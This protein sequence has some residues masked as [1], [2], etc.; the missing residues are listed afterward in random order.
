MRAPDTCDR[1][2]GQRGTLRRLLA[3]TLAAVAAMGVSTSLAEPND[4]RKIV[5]LRIDDVQTLEHLLSSDLNPLACRTALGESDWV[6]SAREFEAL[7]ARG[8][9]TRTL[10]ENVEALVANQRASHDRAGQNSDWYATYRTLAEIETRLSDLASAHPER[11]SLLNLGTSAEGRTIW[12]MKVRGTDAPGKPAVL[13]NGTQHAREWIAAMV[14]VFIA[15]TLAVD[16]ASDPVVGDLLDAVD[17]YV[18][19]VVNPDGYEY[20][21]TTDRFWRKN[22]SNNAGSSCRGVDLN[23]NWDKDWN[24]SESTSNSPCSSVFVGS[25]AF[26]EPE[27]SALRDF[28]LAHPEL[29]GHIDFHNY[30]QVILQ[31]WGY[32]DELPDDF[33]E[34]DALGAEMSRAIL[35]VHGRIYPH[36]SGSGLLYL[37]SGIAPDW[38]HDRSIFGYT[39]ELRPSG[40]G[41]GGFELPPGEIRPTAEENYAGALKMIQWARPATCGNDTL[42]AGEEC[43]GNIDDVCPGSCLGN[44]SAAPCRCGGACGDGVCETAL[45][46][47]QASCPVDCGN[48]SA[49]PRLDCRPAGARKASLKI[50]DKERDRS[51]KL[52]L[53][54]ANGPTPTVLDDFG[55]PATQTDTRVELCLYGDPGSGPELVADIDVSGSNRWRANSS[56][57]VY[58]DSKATDDGV[59][60]IVLKAAVPSKARLKF[61]AKGEGLEVPPLPMSL[62]VRAQIVIQ[63]TTGETCW[64]AEFDTARRN[65]AETFKARTP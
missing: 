37:A 7:Q 48:C 49:T 42:E 31:P 59:K 28:V 64:E 2:I 19:P 9:P 14:P 58:V 35:E 65:T 33:A 27:T 40:T 22:R 4:D 55:D 61:Q 6:V 51:D 11:I 56:G 13:F 54:W 23:R 24:G 60:K 30:S 16:Y 53:D 44:A 34:V 41:G 43:D 18:V 46:E 5:R 38:T 25:E 3:M 20:S 57:F 29:K 45:G 36:A 8:I 26:S 63:S 1:R 32:T 52:T 12:G 17:V 47:T 39:V 10:V 50:S 21:H 62:P 15:E